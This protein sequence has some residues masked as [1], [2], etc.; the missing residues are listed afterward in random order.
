MGS[1]VSSGTHV[2]PLVLFLRY[3]PDIL[4]AN[5]GEPFGGRHGPCKTFGLSGV[6][7]SRG[8]ITM[9]DTG[10]PKHLRVQGAAE[11]SVSM[12]RQRQPFFWER[13]VLR[14]RPGLVEQPM[15]NMTRSRAGQDE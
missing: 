14:G 3:L 12:A 5:L 4:P 15:H 10:E 1:C 8:E 7:T 13:P 11:A 2:T 6:I 9:L